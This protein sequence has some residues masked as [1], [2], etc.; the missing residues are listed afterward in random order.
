MRINKHQPVPLQ[1]YLSKLIFHWTSNAPSVK[2]WSHGAIKWAHALSPNRPSSIEIERKN[3]LNTV[4]NVS[5]VHD[6]LVLLDV[7]FLLLA[8]RA[9]AF[10]RNGSKNTEWNAKTF[11]GGITITYFTLRFV[12]NNNSNNGAA[13]THK[14]KSNR[15]KQ[16][17]V[18]T[19]KDSHKLLSKIS[20]K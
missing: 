1:R 5:I 17:V 9:L 15:R 3:M 4:L 10:D 19:I 20:R 2:W 18:T 16:H 12:F 7:S 11:T 14:K 6:R 8:I 13:N